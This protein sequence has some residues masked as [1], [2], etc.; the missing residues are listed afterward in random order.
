MRHICRNEEMKS[1]EFDRTVTSLRDR[2]YRLAR[3]LL[4]RDDEAQDVTHDLLERLWM[5]RDRLD[6]CR[7][8]E[9]FVMTALRNACYDRL[10]RRSAEG[11][12]EEAVK[13]MRSCVCDEGEE[14]DVRELV[15]RAIDSLP[16]LQRE[17]IHLREIEG[18]KT[19]EVALIVGTD[20]GHVRMTLSRARRQLKAIM[21]RTY[22]YGK[23]EA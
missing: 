1:S 4:L 19:R 12:L 13:E 7:N 14:R 20:E 23:A 22:G 21:E 11:R 15:R 5:R 8:R 9:A 18:Y 2:M 17:V 10:R 16:P 3:S 6:E